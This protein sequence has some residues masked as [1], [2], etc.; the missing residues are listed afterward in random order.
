MW[1]LVPA[2]LACLTLAAHFLRSGRFGAVAVCFLIPSLALVA[3]RRWALRLLQGLLGLGA[4]VWMQ[5]GVRIGAERL[6]HG[7]PWMRMAV[8]LGS[9][10]GFSAVAVWLLE[11]PP[12]LSKYTN[13]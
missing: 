1:R 7:E 2:F 4:L 8:I 12:V 11:Q 13:K 10:A 5:T 3:R 9:V 6:Q